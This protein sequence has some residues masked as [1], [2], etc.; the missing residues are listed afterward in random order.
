MNNNNNNN[1]S[2]NHR[3]QNQSNRYTRLID[4]LLENGIEDHRKYILRKILP[5]YLINIRGFT[6]EQCHDIL[7]N[8]LDVKCRALHDLDFK[9]DDLLKSDIRYARKSGV[10][11]ISLKRL[12]EENPEL[13][14]RLGIE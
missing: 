5:R 7:Y 12:Q 8:W 4:S 14:Q 13:Y 10:K 1:N 6:D 2:Q 11:S 9:P 3:N